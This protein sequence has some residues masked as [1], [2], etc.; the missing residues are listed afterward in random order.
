M[1]RRGESGKS[2]RR[3]PGSSQ[4][5]TGEAFVQQHSKR[6]SDKFTA[7]VL[8]NTASNHFQP[9]GIPL[10][11]RG[12]QAKC[13]DRET[14]PACLEHTAPQWWLLPLLS[15]PLRCFERSRAGAAILR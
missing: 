8:D 12:L 11:L 1:A 3:K 10:Q 4:V 7:G 5:R 14:P 6:Q 2:C 9:A 13:V 15:A